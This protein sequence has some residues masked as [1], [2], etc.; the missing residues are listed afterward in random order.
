MHRDLKS[1]NVLID[2]GGVIKLTDFGVSVQ[3][4]VLPP[5]RLPPTTCLLPPASCLLLPAS[6]RLPPAACLLPP[7]ACLLPPAACRLPPAACRLPPAASCPSHA[8]GIVVG[9]EE[10]WAG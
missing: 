1:A 9:R 4:K 8:A 6:Y 3:V 7:A 5:N 2:C 10:W